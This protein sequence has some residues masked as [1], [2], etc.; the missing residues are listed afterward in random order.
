MFSSSESV[1]TID[2]QLSTGHVPTGFRAQESDRSHQVFRLA[3][4][5]LGNQGGP[6]LLQVW[7]LIEDFLGAGS[8]V[9][10]NLCYYK[11]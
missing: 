3:H 9:S 5:A 11:T 10:D 1:A 2:A 4:F 7:V 6:G 8:D